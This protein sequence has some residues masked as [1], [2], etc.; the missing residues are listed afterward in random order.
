[1]DVG[2]HDFDEHQRICKRCGASTWEWVDSKVECGTGDLDLTGWDALTVQEKHERRSRNIAQAKARQERGKTAVADDFAF[3]RQR[4][5]E[6]EKAEEAARRQTVDLVFFSQEPTHVTWL[7]SRTHE[8]DE[9][10]PLAE[11]YRVRDFITGYSAWYWTEHGGLAALLERDN[12]LVKSTER[13]HCNFA[14]GE[15]EAAAVTETEFPEDETWA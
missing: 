8:E 9:T 2:P 1:M 14:T 15:A 11:G 3:I 12:L 6:I 10:V 5:M 13:Y 4:Q 7:P